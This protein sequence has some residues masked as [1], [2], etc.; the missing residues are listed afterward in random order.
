[1]YSISLKNKK[2]I[3]INIKNKSDASSIVN[4]ITFNLT[5][6]KEI[7]IAILVVQNEETKA[8]R[9]V[10]VQANYSYERQSHMHVHFILFLMQLLPLRPTEKGFSKS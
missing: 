8:P 2:I 9:H 3:G 10:S 5:V 6:I 1:M 4:G 7:S